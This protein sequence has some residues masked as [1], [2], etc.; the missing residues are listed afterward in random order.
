LWITDAGPALETTASLILELFNGA[1]GPRFCSV[2]VRTEEARLAGGYNEARYGVVCDPANWG[3]VALRRGGGAGGGQPLVCYRVHPR[4]ATSG[5]SC[6]QWQAWGANIGEDLAEG[7]RQ[8]GVPERY[9]KSARGNMMANMTVTILIQNI[10]PPGWISYVTG[11]VL[12]S[13]RL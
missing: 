7:L 1:R 2:I 8:R 4:S 5:S 11:E 3:K 12:R 10:G 13:W 6:R 9:I